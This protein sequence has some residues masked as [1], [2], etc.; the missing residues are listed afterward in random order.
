[1]IGGAGGLGG[2][3]GTRLGA[4]IGSTGTVSHPGLLDIGPVP[5]RQEVFAVTDPA[6]HTE[7]ERRLAAADVAARHPEPLDRRLDVVTP[8]TAD[9]WDSLAIEDLT[10][11]EASAFWQAISG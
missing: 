3:G 6:P 8:M 1:V 10:E 2:A 7:A 4:G 11:D 5:F 9:R